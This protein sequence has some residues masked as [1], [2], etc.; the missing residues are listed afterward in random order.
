ML[1][2]KIDSRKIEK[3]D[4]F[5]A[6]KGTNVDGHDYIKQALLNGAT[7]VVLEQDQELSC[8]KKLVKDTKKWLDDYL[9]NHYAAQINEL[10]LIGVTGT[11]G[12]TTSCFLIYQLLKKLGQKVA[13]IGTIG[14]YY[15]DDF[16]ELPNT[17]PNI[18]DLYDLILTAL[19]KGCQ[20]IVMEVSSH[21]LDLQRIAGLKFKIVGFTNLTQDHLD[22]HKTMENY[23]KAKLKIIDYLKEDGILIVN[24]DDSYSKYFKFKQR[25]T[26]G[27]EKGDYVAEEYKDKIEK[28]YLKL[29][30][31][32]IS[33]EIILNLKNK[34]N[35]YNYLLVFA[36]LDSLG[37][38]KEE[39]ISKTKEIYPPKGRS[40]QIKV[41][42]GLAI[43]D[44]AHT[45]DAVLKIITSFKENSSAK[46]ITIVGCGG[47][48]D[49]KKRP[50]M[51]DIATTYSDYVI[52]TNDNPRTEDPTKIM[53]DI[54]KGVKKDNY[55][56]IYDRKEAIFKGLSLIKTNTI[57]LVLGKGHEDYQ[58]IGYEKIHFDDRE[59]IEEFLNLF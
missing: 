26:F 3:G 34:F 10:T 31:K 55:E 19:E 38:A 28:S 6:L 29:K 41:K 36:V 4:T 45:P 11:N 56:I 13:Y 59:V 51:G 14:Y 39:I 43:I 2:I 50:I 23:L 24:N 25:K 16:Q 35:I 1:K 7:R 22:Y 47:D 30:T 52:F 37:F 48:R 17:T 15:E 58:I 21:A 53:D 46:I 32:N 44:Y 27:F 9:V 54:I 20:Y 12:K 42:K 40:E 57:L 18:L 33:Y 5:V 8:E 49:P